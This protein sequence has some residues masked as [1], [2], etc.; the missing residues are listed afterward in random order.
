M[1]VRQQLVPVTRYVT[2][3]ITPTAKRTRWPWM[4]HHTH[5]RVVV[6]RHEMRVKLKKKKI[7]TEP[8]IRVKSIK[9]TCHGNMSS[10]TRSYVPSSDRRTIKRLFFFF[11]FIFLLVVI[12]C[13][14][15]L[16]S[17]HGRALFCC[18]TTEK[19]RRVNPKRNYGASSLRWLRYYT[20]PMISAWKTHSGRAAISSRRSPAYLRVWRETSPRCR[21]MDLRFRVSLYTLLLPRRPRRSSRL[22]LFDRHNVISYTYTLYGSD[23][24]NRQ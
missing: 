4:L 1:S 11:F 13:P 8:Q 22:L 6:Q 19:R 16:D 23:N 10:Y 2:N 15:V 3:R 21:T 20:P 24:N 14:R 5:T 9:T 7:K 17:Y 18:R 12:F